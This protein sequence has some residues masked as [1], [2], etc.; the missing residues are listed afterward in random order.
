MR[1]P[2]SV[3]GSLMIA[4]A[5]AGLG[6]LPPNA[7]PLPPSDVL[8]VL[9]IPATLFG[10]PFAIWLPHARAG[11]M[12]DHWHVPRHTFL[13]PRWVVCT[14]GTQMIGATLGTLIL[15]AATDKRYGLL[16]LMHLFPAIALV[17]AAR[18]RFSR[19]PSSEFV[20]GL[21]LPFPLRKR[22]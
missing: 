10:I 6:L 4:C 18:R 2:Y 8:Q 21:L 12:G 11:S 9:I 13:V 19:H 1:R 5:Y 14:I 7:R 15:F 16:F 3:I 17:W 20:L 22:I